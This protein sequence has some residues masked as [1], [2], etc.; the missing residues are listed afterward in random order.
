[1]VKRPFYQKNK[2]KLVLKDKN[3]RSYSGNDA[4]KKA[5]ELL[6]K[7]KILAI[8]GVGGY[9]LS[10]NA[11]DDEAVQNL[12]KRKHR[13]EKPFAVMMKNIEEIK[14]YC[15][16]DKIEGKLVQDKYTPI[17]LLLKNA[18]N[19]IAQSVTPNLNTIGVTLPYTRM[20]HLLL[21]ETRFPLVMTSG[22]ISDEPLCKDENEV[23]KRLE[24]IVDGFLIHD[25]KTLDRID[26]SVC[27]YAAGQRIMVRR[28]R[29]FADKHFLLNRSYHPIFAVGS[30]YKNTFC[31]IKNNFAIL[32][33]HIGDLDHVLT[34]KYYIREIKRYKDFF[35]FS[36]VCVATDLHT[37][38]TLPIFA[39]E[40]KLPVIKVQHH[41]AHIASVMAEYNI[42][43][44]VLGVVF[45]GTGLGLDGNIWGGEFFLA[46]FKGFK[47]LGHLKYVQIP[48]GDTAIKNP[49]KS[50]VGF[51]YPNIQKFPELISR[52]GRDKILPLVR[53][54]DI[55]LNVFKTSSMGRLFDAVA[56]LIGVKDTISYQGQGAMELEAMVSD[57]DEFYSYEIMRGPVF[58]IDVK[59][60]LREIYIDLL[61]GVCPGK[62][63]AKFHN[64]I[65]EFTT[66]LLKILRSVYKVD[67][68]VLSG[69]CFQNRFLL[70]N[71]YSRLSKENFKVFIP[72]RVPI[73][74]GG[75]SLG[76]AVIAAHRLEK[77][78]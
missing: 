31:F 57:C 37:G 33:K 5:A 16:L 66:K 71:L 47:R 15:K 36:P 76:Q 22:N 1:M 3:K 12:R 30:M 38:Y 24:N 39:K 20:H 26:D 34:Y 44:K 67:R 62:I 13:K 17:V 14:K 73:N 46:D 9:H 6:K 40:Q 78:M 77:G 74:D 4:I 70:N 59:N 42:E 25:G 72:S 21:Q 18:N 75:I 45:D 43:D 63:S 7:G 2:I 60:M 52:I 55:G 69:G 27:F 54:I 35:D 28:S 50:A 49:F 32:S 68:V 23:K 10:V 61:K 19:D 56:S 53:Q 41:H 29:G 64:T 65:V 48:G 58:Q 11:T 8:K 51:I